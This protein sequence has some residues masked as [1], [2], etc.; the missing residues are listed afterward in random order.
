MKLFLTYLES[1]LRSKFFDLNR[2]LKHISVDKEF[3]LYHFMIIS[4]VPESRFVIKRLTIL[5]QRDTH[6][7]KTLQWRN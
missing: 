6:Y 1:G 3:Y 5:S 2:C 4:K 7:V